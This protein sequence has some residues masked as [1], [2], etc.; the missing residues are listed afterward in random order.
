MPGF[1][2]NP[3]I[4]MTT[5][6][7]IRTS[8]PLLAPSRRLAFD[9]SALALACSL[10]LAGCATPPTGESAAAAAATAAKPAVAVPA[11]VAAAA[12]GV[13]AVAGNASPVGVAA[14]PPAASGPTGAASAPAARP[15]QPP[16]LRAF[17]DVIRT[18][19]R[20]EGFFSI[21]RED[22]K[23]WLEI[24]EDRFG[25]PLHLSIN[26]RNA[27]GERGLYAAFMG[28][29]HTAEFRK[30][31]RT[32]Q[33]VLK[34]T[35]YRAEGDAAMART[36]RESFSDSLLAAG[37]LESAP[38]PERKS[39]LVDATFLLADLLGYGTAV[40]NA[41]RL[42]Y[43]LD[44]ANSYF[45]QT[46][47]TERMSSIGA[48]LHFATPRIPAPPL[49]P[50]PVPL[51]PPP[52]T[53]PDARSFF[54]GVTMNFT[55]LPDK[56]MARRMADPRL[57]YFTESFTD[58]SVE[59]KANNRVHLITRWRLEKKDPAAALSLPVKPIT[60]WLDRNIPQRYRAAV[61]AGVLEWNKAFERI[62]FKDAVVV[63]QQADN[64]DFDL[65]DSEHASI[66]WFTGADVGFARGPSHRDSR[67]G[68]ILDADIQMSDVFGRGA[69]R[70]ILE[71]VGAGTAAR[72]AAM[73][74][75]MTQ[76]GRRA[77]ANFCTYGDEKVAEMAFALDLLESRGDI[78]LD[79]PEAEAFVAAAIKDTI[80]HEV[81][82][83]LGLRHNFR[84]STTVTAA[85]LRDKAWTSANGTAASVM[86]Y[87]PYNVPLKGETLGDASNPTLG[88]YDYWA[89]EYGY[90]QLPAGS[91]VAELAK[92]AG[93]STEPQLAYAD[94]RDAGGF[95]PYEGLDPRD[96]RF[97]QGEDPLAWAERRMKL[98]RELWE[99]VQERGLKPGDEVERPRR[100]LMAGLRQIGNLPGNVAKY[101]GGMYSERD[102]PG[103]SGRPA[104]RPVESA[105]QRQALKF[106]TGSL[107]SS[108]SFRFK[109]E[110]LG[111]LGA[112]YVEWDRNGPVSVAQIVLGLQ[113]MAMDR[114]LAAGPA[115]RL[116]DLPFNLPEKERAG[117]ISLSEVYST[118][119]DAV[120][121][122]LQAKPGAAGAAID[123]DPLRRNLQREHL[124]RVQGLLTRPAPNLPADALSLVRLQAGQLQAVLKA[125]NARRSANVE[126]RA[127]LAD[128]LGS[129][130]EALKATMQRQ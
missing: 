103:T 126:T 45:D 42:P 90:R 107:F 115:Q 29:D 64:A 87:N 49:M 58:Y 108:D 57:G 46:R 51:P 37:G 13:T 68:E 47:A 98:S 124:K 83:T 7:S 78:T 109:P 111:S 123:I 101:I 73:T 55:A 63:Q 15:D 22:E 121:S 21:W 16:P 28:E 44:R 60:Y 113:R 127:H 12:P 89:I 129:L 72:A 114:I 48:Q 61:A 95:G 17:A 122:E 38:H 75:A 86:D 112:D 106:L 6:T 32:V 77:D 125:A 62:G 1:G 104:F 10:A 128:S 117:A 91:E 105:K 67:S 96:S 118:L 92:I 31:G 25:K 56:P 65:S 100:S 53:L 80:M 43:G 54:V 33:L 74:H 2:P 40:E 97:D 24:P 88:A 69:R 30:I 71:D 59:N 94:D 39:V 9:P 11:P 84:A 85:Q 36:V 50:S 66:K 18:A 81:G 35:D 27:V 93:R 14:R 79:S 52:R 4:P 34:N 110:F 116:L 130:N 82:H 8:S 23:V 19:K 102:L 99:R 119:Q 3:I 76:L 120:W 41:F 70:L 20:S 26:V 5:S